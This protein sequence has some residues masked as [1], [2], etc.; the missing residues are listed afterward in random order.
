MNGL[1]AEGKTTPDIAFLGGS[2]VE[3]MSGKWFGIDRDENLKSLKNLFD[4]N[5]KKNAGAQLEAVA[6]GVAGD[7]VR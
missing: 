4:K 2:I 7:T 1:I 6:L 3:E 5:F